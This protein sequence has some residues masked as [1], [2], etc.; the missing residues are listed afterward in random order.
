VTN[1]VRALKEEL[2][3]IDRGYY[4]YQFTENHDPFFR[5]WMDEPRFKELMQRAREGQAGIEV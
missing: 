4:N 2:N 1:F 5:K 3:A